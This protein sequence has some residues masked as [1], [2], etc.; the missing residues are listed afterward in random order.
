MS[1]E[2][3]T[4]RQRQK[5]DLQP[6]L[7][8]LRGILQYEMKRLGKSERILYE[9]FISELNTSF[10]KEDL[11]FLAVS[12]TNEMIMIKFQTQR[13]AICFA[14]FFR[15]WIIDEACLISI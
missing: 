3:K 6:L 4:G 8:I 9:Q 12:S 15:S 10:S 2:K 11:Q 14:Y 5:K 1:R 7:S 13:S